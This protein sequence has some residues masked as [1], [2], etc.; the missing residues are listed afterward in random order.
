MTTL[1]RTLHSDLLAGK[2]VLVTGAAQGIGLGISQVLTEQ[3]AQLVMVDLDA[4]GQDQANTLG[5]TFHQA[6]V[7]DPAAMAAVVTAT[8]QQHGALHGLVNNAGVIGPA[9][10]F[11]AAALQRVVEVN[12]LGA[13]VC[14]QAV[15]PAMTAGGGGAV[16]N[17]SSINGIK[18]TTGAPMYAATKRAVVSLGRHA[19]LEHGPNKIR[20]NTLLPGNVMTQMLQ[21][22]YPLANQRVAL[23][24]LTPLRRLGHAHEAGQATAFLL[25]D[26]A[27][28]INGHALAV[29]GGAL[30]AMELAG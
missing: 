20:I 16:V 29:D 22:S 4:A 14:M 26:A 15:L 2:A 24:R 21:R 23:A 10:L 5:A 11:D 27:S 12:L 8:L 18:G 30:C 7:S 9:T 19:A 13:Y 1:D 3:G 17:V 6:D 28:F 25:S